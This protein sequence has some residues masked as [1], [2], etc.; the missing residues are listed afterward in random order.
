MCWRY[1]TTPKPPPPPIQKQAKNRNFSY[2]THNATQISQNGG[3]LIAS[4][5]MLRKLSKSIT[6]KLLNGLCFLMNTYNIHKSSITTKNKIF[7]LNQISK[8]YLLIDQNIQMIQ[9]NT[10]YTI[11][12]LL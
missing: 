9:I 2:I 11:S 4:M 8:K 10:D 12:S 5:Y 7:F 3:Y 6:N 1:L